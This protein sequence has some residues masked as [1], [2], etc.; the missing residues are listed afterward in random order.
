MQDRSSSTGNTPI[1][2]FKDLN[3][4]KKGHELVLTLYRLT[5][6]FPRE[7]AFGLTTQLRRAGV[8]IT[9]NIAEGFSRQ[10]NREKVQFYATALGSLT[11]T[12]SHL[13]LAKDVGYLSPETYQQAEDQ[14]ITVN[15]I[16]AGLLKHT[17]MRIQNS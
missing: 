17:K 8:S 6:D 13:L 12:Q 10:S 1:R 3:A 15:K 11:E 9:A 2:S 5:K 7:E 4:W 16:L 14:S